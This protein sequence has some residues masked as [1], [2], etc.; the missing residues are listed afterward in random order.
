MIN[1]APIKSSTSWCIWIGSTALHGDPSPLNNFMTT[2]HLLL[3]GEV[4]VELRGMAREMRRKKKK[5]R[6]QRGCIGQNRVAK[7]F[8]MLFRCGHTKNFLVE[9]NEEVAYLQATAVAVGIREIV[10]T[11]EEG[12]K[13]LRCHS[14]SWPTRKRVVMEELRR[15]VM[16]KLVEENTE[17]EDEGK[18]DVEEEVEEDG[19]DEKEGEEEKDEKAKDKEA[20]EEEGGKEEKKRRRP[21]NVQTVVKEEEKPKEEEDDGGEK[22]GDEKIVFGDRGKCGNQEER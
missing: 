7:D 8:Y 10:L 20:K 15:V 12:K 18:K 9:D 6:E 16:E 2:S 17:E 14:R 11:E 22:G 1:N 3:Q 5:L 21:S 19:E 13:M 4:E